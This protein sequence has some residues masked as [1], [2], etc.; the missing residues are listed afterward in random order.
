M[1]FSS[2]SLVYVRFSKD[3]K[4]QGNN[5]PIE[6]KLSIWH[7]GHKIIP[8]AKF[9]SDSSSRFGNMTSQNF[10]RKKG[11]SHQIRLFKPGKRV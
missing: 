5:Q 3:A 10:S 7:Y 2:S 11:T 6:M 4:N 8:D 1:R 9:E